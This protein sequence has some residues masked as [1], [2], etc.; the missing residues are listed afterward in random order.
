MRSPQEV[1]RVYSPGRRRR[2]QQYAD[3]FEVTKGGLFSKTSRDW[4]TLY[5][6]V[7]ESVT[8]MFTQV[9]K[10]LGSTLVELAQGPGHRYQ[11]YAWDYSFGAVKINLQGMDAAGIN[12]A[13]Q[14]YINP[15]LGIRLSRPFS[16]RC[17]SLISR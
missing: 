1:W 4:Y 6:P 15:P 10:N 14:N 8:D 16:A 11:Q 3:I 12:T 5:Q 7:D 9:F 13:L 2:S 17:S